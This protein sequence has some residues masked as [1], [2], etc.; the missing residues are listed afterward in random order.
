M[1]T[2]AWAAGVP[3]IVGALGAPTLT[4]A[5]PAPGASVVEPVL[6]PTW[7]QPARAAAESTQQIR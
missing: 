2:M 7:P 4:A 6:T 5:E 1:P 3:E